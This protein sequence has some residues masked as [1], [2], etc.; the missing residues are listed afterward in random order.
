MATLTAE[1]ILS[2]DDSAIL[3]PITVPEWGGDVYLRM[4]SVGAR[5]SYDRLFIGKRETGI[6]NWRAELL[7]RTLCDENGSLL[8]TTAQ[9]E[10]LADKNAE[11]C[12]RLWDLAWKHNR[13][14]GDAVERAAKN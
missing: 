8:F 10:L 3:G 1:Q 4:M 2:K 7:A 13:M 12:T 9:V 11:P 6:P 14:D 5:D